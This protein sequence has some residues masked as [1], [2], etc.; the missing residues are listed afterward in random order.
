MIEDERGRIGNGF[1][2]SVSVVPASDK[3]VVNAP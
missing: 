1:F 2:I 3:E